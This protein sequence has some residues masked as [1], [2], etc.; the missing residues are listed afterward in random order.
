MLDPAIEHALRLALALLL[1][2][3]ALHKL[4]DLASFRAAVAGYA[5][6]PEALSGAIAGTLACVEASLAAALVA[7]AA[8]GVRTVALGGCAALVGLY[9]LAIG[10][11]LA[12]GRRDIDCGCAGHAGRQTLSGWL[13]ARNGLLAATALVC[14]GGASSRPLHW[15]DALTIGASVAVL[16]TS[17]LAAHR[18]LASA[19]AIARLR[20]G[21]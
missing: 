19:P 10:A 20:E 2:S 17:W 12:R 11:N 21:A 8:W 16:A 3:A 4:R 6:V 15:L 18:L 1:A 14:L 5:L 13:L 7:P 9:A